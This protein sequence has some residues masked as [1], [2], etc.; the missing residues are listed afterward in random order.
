MSV[1]VLSD[2]FVF[3]GATGDL[4]FK[5]I[6]PALSALTKRGCLNMPVI[7]VAR[8]PLSREQFASH[9][10]DSLK[11]HG[12]VAPATFKKLS[13]RLQYVSGDY[14]DPTTYTKLHE[15]LGKATHPIYYLAIPPSMFATVIEGLGKAGSATNARVIVE[16]PFG[17]DLASARELNRV[18]RSVFA[19]EAIFRI[20]HYLGKEPVQNIVYTRFANA[21]F[22]PVWNS[23]YIE[24]VQ[25][26]MAEDFGVE[27]RGSLYEETGAIRDVIQNHMLQLT[28]CVAMEAPT[29]QKAEALRD[30]RGAVLKAIKPLKA[31]QVVRGQYQGYRKVKGVAA[32]SSVETFAALKLYID[33]RRWAGVPFYIRAGKCL[34]VTAC[35]IMIKFKR[36]PLNVFEE[37]LVGNPNYIRL[38]ISPEIVSGLGLRSK[39]PGEEMVGEKEE[40]SLRENPGDEMSPYERLLGDAMRGETTLF[41]REDGVEAAWSVVEPILSKENVLYLYKPKSW[42]PAEADQLIGEKGGWYNPKAKEKESS[43]P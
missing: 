13:S 26:T 36:P 12:G 39:R 33:N 15:A 35:E 10:Q 5:Q 7:G 6:F 22:E 3:F 1:S 24:Q 38:K 9:V 34:P 31:T 37:D 14:N 11:Q 42:G 2:T 8:R 25:I 43:K 40:L 4:A 41:A 28:A 19:E 32:A 23:N 16:K 17:R 18:L 27:D 20:D 29:S 30:A 21:I